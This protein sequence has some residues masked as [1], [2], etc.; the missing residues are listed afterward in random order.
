MAG[1]DDGLTSGMQ[2]S[3]RDIAELQSALQKW[4][5]TTLPPG[6]APQISVH[7]AA[8]TNGMS[9]E[10]VLLDASWSEGSKT[11]A[12]AL[13][14]R[15]APSLADVP[16]FPNYDLHRQFDTLNLIA[17][18]TEV[19]VPKMLWLEDDPAALGSPFF[20]MSRVEG[21]VPPDMLP[22]TFG[23][24]WLYES[25]D[26]DLRVLQDSSVSVLAQLHAIE[27]AEET[28]GFLSFGTEGGDWLERHVA[29]TSAWYEFA[30]ADTGRSDLIENCFKWLYDHWPKEVSPTVLS[31][32]D[33]RIGNVMY[34]RYQPVAVLDWE[35]AGLGPRELDVSWMI[36]SHRVFQ[37]IVEPLGLPGMPSFMLGDEVIETYERLSGETIRDLAFYGTYAAI[38]W[39]IV[40]LRTG[41]R[42]AHFGEITFPDNPDDLL[43]HRHTLAKMAEGTYWD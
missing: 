18:L 3:T 6:S 8:S 22:Y 16:V 28:F 36:F 12:E 23:D 35:M 31:W 25:S 4:F 42:Q 29:H 17:K 7:G 26:A 32:G 40:F 24:N 15:M 37:D 38:Q 43:H 10:T 39:G 21:E 14:A 2:R 34:R 9:S 19:P 41:A 13:V 27:N 33:A 11:R 5:E 1:E 20:V 30:L